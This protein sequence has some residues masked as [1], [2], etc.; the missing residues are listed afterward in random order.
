MIGSETFIIVAFKC[1][2]SN[3]PF[4]FASAISFAANSFKAFKLN[5]DESIIS[6]AFNGEAAFKTVV[7][8]FSAVNSITN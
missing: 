8:L 1:T 4:A 5:T 3:N 2:E 7:V 6:P